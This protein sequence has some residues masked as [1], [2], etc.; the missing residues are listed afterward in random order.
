MI[1]KQAV[2]W[3][4]ISAFERR[5]HAKRNRTGLLRSNFG[6]NTRRH[7]GARSCRRDRSDK[8]A[9]R[10]QG[11]AGDLNVRNGSI[12]D[13]GESNRPLSDLRFK[14]D[15]QTPHNV[16]LLRIA[17]WSFAARVMKQRVPIDQGVGVHGMSP[18]APHAADC[19]CQVACYAA[20]QLHLGCHT[21]L[22]WP[23]SAQIGKSLMMR[24]PAPRGIPRS[25]AP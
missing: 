7:G 5:E 15:D 14:I 17:R 19:R 3:Q 16:P 25:R 9:P 4:V 12:A 1:P 23:P 20:V 18:Q 21:S 13:V 22:D 10:D 6:A 8:W 2:R 24:V 11:R